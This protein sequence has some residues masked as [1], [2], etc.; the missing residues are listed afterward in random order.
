MQ[1]FLDITKP[2]SKS[3]LEEMKVKDEYIL[4]QKIE[5]N[6]VK[7]I[8]SDYEK[9]SHSTYTM[10]IINPKSGYAYRG[11]N[12][13]N[14]HIKER[15]DIVF[16]G[17]KIKLKNK[18]MYGIFLFNMFL[19]LHSEEKI[20]TAKQIKPWV[21]R[22]LVAKNFQPI[23][24][25]F[26]ILTYLDEVNKVIYIDTEK[27][28]EV[29]EKERSITFYDNQKVFYERNGYTLLDIK[30]RP[31]SNKL[32]MSYVSTRYERKVEI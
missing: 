10:K 23:V 11:E 4:L 12:F 13:L 16:S 28:H 21:N 7:I 6:P 29:T 18:P 15:G 14:Y 27:A 20:L 22:L 2:N 5:E 31:K 24:D 32:F 1:K 9:G 25:D 19:K 30:E 26:S 8:K 3:I 17:M